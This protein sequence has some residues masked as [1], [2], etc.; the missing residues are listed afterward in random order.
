MEE[1]S[2]GVKRGRSQKPVLGDIL[3]DQVRARYIENFSSEGM[4]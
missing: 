2:S 4:G 3:A 1:L